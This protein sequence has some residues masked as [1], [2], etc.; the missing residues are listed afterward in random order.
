MM[1]LK[2]FISHIAD[3]FSSKHSENARTERNSCF[4][5]GHFYSPIIDIDEI[6]ARQKEIWGRSEIDGINAIDLKLG[7]QIELIK[8]LS[9][10]Y[11]DIPFKAKKQSDIRYYFENDQY[12]YCDAIVLYSMMRYFK[13]NRII[14]VGSGFS[15]AIMLDVNELFF[16]NTIDLTFIEPYTE[17]LESILKIGD[18]CNIIREKV[19][20]VSVDAFEQLGQNDILFIDSTHVAKTGSDVNYIIFEVLPALQSGVLIH[21]HDIFYPFEYP[22]EWVFEGRNWNETYLLKAFLMYNESFDIYL[23]SHYLH[24]HHKE[25]FAD[26]PLT[27]LNTGGNLWLRKK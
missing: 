9:T 25:T 6:K 13:P 14:E 27:Y 2:N 4:P 24:M 8:K 16:N 17:R 21:F 10:F 1:A 23:L 15:S 26:M 7:D 12:S 20:S 3:K 18:Q 5:N 19:Q 11:P 22:Q